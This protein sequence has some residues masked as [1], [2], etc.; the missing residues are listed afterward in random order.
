MEKK[1]ERR[2]AEEKNRGNTEGV[3][4]R[5]K[6]TQR[7]LCSPLQQTTGPTYR[8]QNQKGGTEREQ[9]KRKTKKKTQSRGEAE[10]EGTKKKTV[11]HG[12]RRLKNREEG[13]PRAEGRIPAI[14]QNPSN[15]IQHQVSSSLFPRLDILIYPVLCRA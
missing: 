11:K 6:K 12:K 1:R 15:E 5:Q 10:K 13:R 8:T 14:F 2:E 9:E 7:D 3:K 4:K